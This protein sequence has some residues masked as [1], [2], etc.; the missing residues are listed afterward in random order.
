MAHEFKHPNYYKGIKTMAKYDNIDKEIYSAPN[1]KERIKL[2]SEAGTDEFEIIELP[3]LIE[4]FEEWKKNNKG[5]FKDFL[6]D[7]PSKRE[8]LK[9]G[10]RVR[11]GEGGKGESSFEQLADDWL[12]DIQVIYID[13]KK[14]EFSDYV[15]RMGGFYDID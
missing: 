15:K 1:T 6:N 14:E 12:D 8:K 13:G 4:A 2:A 10:G 9:L 5:T 11:L 7:N 3:S